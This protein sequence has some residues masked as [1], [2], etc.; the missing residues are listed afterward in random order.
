MLLPS[1]V[2]ILCVCVCH[3]EIDEQLADAESS[4]KTLQKTV[5][6]VKVLLLLM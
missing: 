3:L 5:L 2:L 4:Q 6:I 1:L